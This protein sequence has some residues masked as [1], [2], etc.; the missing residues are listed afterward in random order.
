M[1]HFKLHKP[2]EYRLVSGKNLVP[3]EGIFGW[4]KSKLSSHPTTYKIL[5]TSLERTSQTYASLY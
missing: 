4:K 1:E 5:D 3:N 2:K